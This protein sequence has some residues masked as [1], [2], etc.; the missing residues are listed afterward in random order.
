MDET[1]L[2]WSSALAF[3]L[4][5]KK[6]GVDN[7]AA[8]FSVSTQWVEPQ[9]RT[10]LIGAAEYSESGGV[11]DDEEYFAH[12]RHTHQWSA[13]LDYELF[14]QQELQPFTHDRKRSLFG[15]GLRSGTSWKGFVGHSGLGVMKETKSAVSDQNQT[16]ERETVRLNFYS[17]LKYR[18]SETANWVGLVYYQPEMSNINNYQTVISTGVDAQV[19]EP[20]HLLFDV[21]YQYD[22]EPVVPGLESKNLKYNFS[23]EIQF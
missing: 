15:V 10:F 3:S 2:G 19:F 11:K 4:A 6:G 12:L 8:S 7:D 20:M 9:S 14:A 13:N 1:Q 5:G 17:D 18:F 21:T 16:N 22:A 23:F